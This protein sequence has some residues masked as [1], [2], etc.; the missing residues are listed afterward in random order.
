MLE[1]DTNDAILLVRQLQKKYL[2]RSLPLNLEFV[3]L[4]KAFSRILYYLVELKKLV[5]DAWLVGA[6]Q[7]M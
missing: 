7:A 2:V 1:R 3:N 4:E 5:G 6:A